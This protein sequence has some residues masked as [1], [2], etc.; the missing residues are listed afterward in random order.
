MFKTK[1]NSLYLST[2]SLITSCRDWYLN[3]VIF[4]PSTLRLSFEV[5]PLFG[6]LA[7]MIFD[8]SKILLLVDLDVGGDY[9]FIELGS[10]SLLNCSKATWLSLSILFFNLESREL[11]KAPL[12]EGL[13]VKFLFFCLDGTFFFSEVLA[14]SIL[15]PKVF[16]SLE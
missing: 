15:S 16:I 10:N 14:V 8:L 12:V 6:G 3:G 9:S 7:G 13:M 1:R 11:F 2:F 5:N 4:L